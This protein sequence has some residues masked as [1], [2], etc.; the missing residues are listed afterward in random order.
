MRL[1]LYKYHGQNKDYL[2]YDTIQNHRK[3]N[4]AMIRML[5]DRNSG[6]GSDGIIVGPEMEE[7]QIGMRLYLADGTEGKKDL[8]AF[9]VFAK[10]LKDNLYVTRDRFR[11]KNLDEAVTV[12]YGDEE[13]ADITVTTRAKDGKDYSESSHPTEVGAMILS[14]EYLESLMA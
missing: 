9:P 14:P 11:L 7:D 8:H 2:V 4:K 10:Y 13:T 5:C 12:H 3:L 6:L 1:T